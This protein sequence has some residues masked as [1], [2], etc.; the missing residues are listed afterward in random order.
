MKK[1]I[2][3]AL[4]CA[5]MAVS[6][7]A[8]CGKSSGSGSGDPDK[9]SVYWLNMKP[10]ADAALQEIAATYTEQ[11]G[12]EV[13]VVTAASG[14]YDSTLTAEM[15]KSQAPTLFVIGKDS[16]VK[17]WGSYAYDLKDTDVYNE[18][19]TDAFTLYDQDGKA[20]SIAYCYES[21]GIIVNKTLLSQ[22]GYSVEDIT[23]FDSLKKVA[24]DIHARSAEL[25]FDAFTSSGMDDSSSWRFTGHLANMPLFY[26]SVDDGWTECPAEIKGTYLDNFKAV[27]DMYTTDCAYDRASLATGGY[28]AEGEFLQGKAVFFQNGSWEYSALSEV[29]SNDE[30]AMIPIY[31][32]VDGEENAGLCSGTENCWA[33]NATTSEA[34]IKATLDFM[35][36]MVTSEEGTACLAKEMGSIPYKGAAEVDNVFLQ[37]ANDMLAAGNYNVDWTFSYTPN[38]DDWRATLVAAM[39]QYDN[40]G[41]WDDVQTAFVAGWANQYQAANAD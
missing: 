20:C 23:N 33:V 30:L 32:G 7:L 3:C 8:G 6:L 38:V 21:Y 41:S 25:G 17:T 13:K 14:S 11:T 28:D 12:V 36:W 24:D 9:G 29:Y 40:G 2:L 4:M 26:E 31:C 22:A 18:L 37:T 1:R 19:T 16:S 39:N 10:E 27:W 34:N 35:Y 5:A 15:A